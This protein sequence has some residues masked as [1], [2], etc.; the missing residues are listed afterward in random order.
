MSLP[1][2]FNKWWMRVQLEIGLRFDAVPNKTMSNSWKQWAW[3]PAFGITRVGD[4]AN[5]AEH[6]E[7]LQF[8]NKDNEAQFFWIHGALRILGVDLGVG[9]F[10]RKKWP[11]PKTNAGD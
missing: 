4:P 6:R 10:W 9:F 2:P 8:F 11:Y 3:S 7:F 1:D 5:Y